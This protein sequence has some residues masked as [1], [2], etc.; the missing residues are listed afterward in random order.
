MAQELDKALS[1]K[2]DRKFSKDKCF[3]DFNNNKVILYMK[4]EQFEFVNLKEMYEFL[5]AKKLRFYVYTNH[6]DLFL[7]LY[8]DYPKAKYKLS[9]SHIG[10]KVYALNV[11][12]VV[13]FRDM[14]Y[15][16]GSNNFSAAAAMEI[17]KKDNNNIRASFTSNLGKKIEIDS[18]KEKFNPISKALRTIMINEVPKGAIILA[19]TRKEFANVYCYDV[20]SA[21]I[22]CLLEGRMPSQFIKTK[23]LQK[24]KE[25]FGRVTIKGLKAKDTKLLTLYKT[26]KMEGKNIALV[27][28]RVIAAEKYSFYCFLNEKWIIDQY[29]NYESF[30]IDLNNLYLIKFEKLPLKTIKA[31]QRLY[32]DKLA[33]KGQL[34]YDGFKQIVNRIYGF[35]LTKREKKNG[36]TDARD[37]TVPYQIGIWII[38]RQ[39]MFICSLIAA[40]GI[41]HVVSAHTDGVKFDCN[42]DEIVNKI[43][44]KRGTIYKDVG[45]WKKEEVFDKCYYFSN[46]VAKYQIGNTIGMKHGGI[47]QIDIDEFLTGKTYDQINGNEDF[48]LT[49]SKEIVCE[50]N[51]TYIK[52]NKSLSNFLLIAEGEL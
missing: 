4:E 36:E 49:C 17:I 7:R 50:K 18:L 34:D 31:I 3:I 22:A 45:Q 11:A 27:G 8:K 29:Y 33:A 46:T 21:Y 24:G 35:F 37:Y 30:E 1:L 13:S 6:L 2:T 12:N 26:D 48:Y 14:K 38:H 10:K 5:A 9:V 39:R 32:D 51:R 42:A 25:H 52:R 40:V 19:Q 43:N 20:C 15:R 44:I 28:S 16:Y 47:P 41:S 23:I